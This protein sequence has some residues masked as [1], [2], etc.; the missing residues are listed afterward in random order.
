[1]INNLFYMKGKNSMKFDDLYSIYQD[2]YGNKVYVMAIAEHG[3]TCETM[4]VY[5][6]FTEE[7]LTYVDSEDWFLNKYTKCA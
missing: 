6:D 5:H 3:V 4:I 2:K 1:M 7:K